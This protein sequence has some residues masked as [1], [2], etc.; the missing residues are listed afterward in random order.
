M[1]FFKKIMNTRTLAV[2]VV[3]AVSVTP[4]VAYNVGTLAGSAPAG[5]ADGTGTAAKFNDPRAMVVDSSG[6]VYVADKNNNCI[7]KITPQGVV[8]TFA[9]SNA[10]GYADG[11]GSAAQFNKPFGLAIDKDSNLYVSDQGNNRIR[12]ITPQGVVTTIVG[13]GTAGLMNAAGTGAQFNGPCAIALDSNGNLY[14]ADTM[15]HCIRKISSQ[16]IVTTVAGSGVAGYIDST[17]TAA[18]FN[19]PVGIVVD[20]AGIIYVSDA[21]NNIIRKITQQGVVTTLAGTTVGGC[22]DGAG[23]TAQF[24]APFLITVDNQGILYVADKL[25]NR[26][27]QITSLYGVVKTFAGS[28]TSGYTDAEAT[29][30]LFSGPTGVATDN[31]GTFYVADN[32]IIRVITPS[33]Y[34]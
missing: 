11:T 23:I 19:K 27:R 13:S 12:K 26:I 34:Y 16:G 32:D 14:V 8:T 6:N 30:A 1:N 29:S 25:N 5:Y 20:N 7:R 15:N 9:G 3:A 31:K 22:V 18:Q 2:A 21:G 4:C 24:N 17:G 33:G 28:A 10:A